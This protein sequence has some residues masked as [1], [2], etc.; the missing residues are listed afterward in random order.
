MYDLHLERLQYEHTITPVAGY[1]ILNGDIG[2][3][4]NFERYRDFLA[5]Q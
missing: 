1:L 3:F 5:K 4:C 2:K